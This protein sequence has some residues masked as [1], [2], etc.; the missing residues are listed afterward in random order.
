M[1]TEA[2]EEEEEVHIRGLQVFVFSVPQFKVKD[3]IEEGDDEI[4]DDDLEHLVDV[5]S[6]DESDK[7]VGAES[8]Q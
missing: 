7:E 2:E 8:R 3:N 4:Q 1:D 5:P 6:D